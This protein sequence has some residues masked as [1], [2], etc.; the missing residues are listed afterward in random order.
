MH[1]DG[2]HTGSAVYS[3]LE[4]AN[5]I[6]NPRAGGDRRLL[7]A[8]LSRQHHR[9]VRYLEKNP[10]HFRLLAV[11]LQQ[12]LLLPPE[13]LP[14]YMDFIAGGC[15]AL[16]GLRLQEHDLQDHRPWDTDA[17][18]ITGF[19]SRAGRSPGPTTI[20]TSWHMLRTQPVWPLGR[21]SRTAWRDV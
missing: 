4:L 13:S 17:V 12:G 11:G 16:L 18:G 19:M 5:R 10:F 6:V 20:R 15:R 3:E 21:H 1:I 9:G 14:R 7:L 8:A 2:E